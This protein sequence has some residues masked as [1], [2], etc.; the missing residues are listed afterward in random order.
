MRAS[1]SGQTSSAKISS[2]SRPN[3]RDCNSSSDLLAAPPRDNVCF[4]LFALFGAVQTPIAG[5]TT[6]LLPNYV[7]LFGERDTQRSDDL[8][9]VKVSPKQIGTVHQ[10]AGAARFGEAVFSVFCAAR[11]PCRMTLPSFITNE[12][13][14]VAVIS[15]LGS[16]GT[17]ITSASF[18]FSSVPSF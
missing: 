16:P 3:R 4:D 6:R 13:C 8:S 1:Q 7:A 5:S 10:S 14:S 9:F 18:P 11:G 17:A 12:T 2:A 15:T